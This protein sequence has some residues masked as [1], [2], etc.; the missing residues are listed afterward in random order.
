MMLTRANVVPPVGGPTTVD[1]TENMTALLVPDG[2]VT[3][4]FAVVAVEGSVSVAVTL[5]SLTTATL[6]TVTPPEALTAV[7]PVRAVPVKVMFTLVLT[8]P[9]VGLMAV[10]TGAGGGGVVTVKVTPL[11]DPPAVVTTTLPVDAPVGTVASMV[12]LFQL[13]AVAGIPLNVTVLDPWT[14]PK[15]VPVMT[16]DVPTGPEEGLTVVIAGTGGGVVVTVNGM[17]LL[18]NPPTVTTTLPVVAPAGT[19]TTMLVGLQLVTVAGV[20]LKVTVPPDPKFDPLMVTVVPTIPELG[21]RPLMTGAV[22]GGGPPPPQGGVMGG[23]TLASCEVM[24]MSPLMT[25]HQEKPI[26]GTYP[27][28]V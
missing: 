12:V 9:E 13:V 5:V 24:S 3:V 11:L 10:S 14:T 1:V 16:T 4:I 6:L 7:V 17:P 2:V 22:G 18:A 23:A 21:L 19:V 20:P 28:P 15:F 27:G 26:N 25:P 8:V